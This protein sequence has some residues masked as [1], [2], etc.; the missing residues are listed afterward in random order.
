MFA[1]QDLYYFK[2]NAGGQADAWSSQKIE[3]T[4]KVSVETS[5]EELMESIALALNDE[6]VISL[7]DRKK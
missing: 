7:I 6:N 3:T 1:G 5:E 2:P 4:Q